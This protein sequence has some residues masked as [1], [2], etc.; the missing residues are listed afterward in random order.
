VRNKL[1]AR[2]TAG[3]GLVTAQH[4]FKVGEQRAQASA[5]VLCLAQQLAERLPGMAAQLLPVVEK[6]GAGSSLSLVQAFEAYLLQP[7]QQLA[8][9]EPQQPTVLLL[10]DAL[11]EADAGG[12]GWL[13]VAALVGKE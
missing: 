12:R 9:Q 7:L 6:H 13:P 5:M 3:R 2:A 11:D 1:V 10:I 4:F 8:Q